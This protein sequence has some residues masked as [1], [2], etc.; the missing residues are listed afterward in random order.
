MATLAIMAGGLLMAIGIAWP[1]I[2]GLRGVPDSSGKVTSK[3]TA[4]ACL[5]LAVILGS[6]A[7][8][9]PYLLWGL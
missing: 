7:I 9:A 1:G 3:G 6:A 5:V 4:V 8:L 2:Q